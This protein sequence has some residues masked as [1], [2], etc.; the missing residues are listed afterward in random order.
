[1]ALNSTQVWE[2]DANKGKQ[3]FY[4]LKLERELTS[5][6]WTPSVFNQIVEDKNYDLLVH[7]SV[8]K[9][10][11]IKWKFV[12]PLFLFYCVLYAIFLLVSTYE[13]HAPVAMQCVNCSMLH[14]DRV[15]VHHVGVTEPV[16]GR[17][18]SVGMWTRA[19][20]TD[21]TMPLFPPPLNPCRAGP[22]YLPILAHRSSTGTPSL[23]L[24]G[25]CFSGWWPS[26]CFCSRSGR[27]CM[28]SSWASSNAK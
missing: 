7:S 20:G 6:H 9:L 27:S 21:H 26:V 24:C 15:L 12:R 19:V 8:Q 10:M 17:P 14:T 18:L 5:Q 11:T 4:L 25:G 23:S 3:K 1:M 16:Q 2:K 13:P 28:K 22:S